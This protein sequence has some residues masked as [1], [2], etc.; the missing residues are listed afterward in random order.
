MPEYEADPT[1]VFDAERY[2]VKSAAQSAAEPPA[3]PLGD[4]ILV[5]RDVEVEAKRGA[6]FLPDNVK[7]KPAEGVVIAVGEGRILDNG[8]RIKVALKV[9]ERI[10]FGK[11]AG[12]EIMIEDEQLLILRE[13]EALAVLKPRPE[14]ETQS[15]T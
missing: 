12:T 2:R 13:D 10:A 11:Y 14:P 5:R 6:V 9:G 8:T 7:E 3:R 15:Q 1:A 4:R